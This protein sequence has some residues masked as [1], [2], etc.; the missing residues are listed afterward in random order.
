[1]SETEDRALSPEKAAAQAA[2]FLGVFA[3]VDF[4]LGGGKTWRLP[5][6]SYM[7]RDMKRRYNEHLRF[8]NKDLQKEEIA[9]PV[10]GKKREQTIW[11]L[12]YND[13]L[14]DED[15]LLCVALMDDS[16]DAGVAARTAYLKDGTLPDVYEQ[17][18]KAGGVA[19]QVQVHWRVMS[20]QM[21]E[22]VKRDPFRN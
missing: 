15:E 8:M 11:P 21:E 3:G 20:L 5:N 19:G 7:P 9:D 12:Q 22:R 16:D 17:F 10:T 18:L 6:P 13:Q 2:E 4:D 1:M 14:I